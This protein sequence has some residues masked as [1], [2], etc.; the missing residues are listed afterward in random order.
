MIHGRAE[1]EVL[2]VGNEEFPVGRGKGTAVDEK[3]GSCEIG[4]LVLTSN[5]S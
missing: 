4:V 2:E 1:I 5:G 3:F